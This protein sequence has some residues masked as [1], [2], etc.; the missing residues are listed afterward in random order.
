MRDFVAVKEIVPSDGSHSG[1][2]YQVVIKY[3]NRCYVVSIASGDESASI[4]YDPDFKT[5]G[6]SCILQMHDGTYLL[7]EGRAEHIV[8]LLSA[9]DRHA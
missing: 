7:V 4:G 6:D 3:I 8:N 5:F 1:M 9:E 2:E